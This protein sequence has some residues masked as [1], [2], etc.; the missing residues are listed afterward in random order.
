MM[1][2]YEFFALLSTIDP[3]LAP[4]PLPNVHIAVSYPSWK[5]ICDAV[6]H[7]YQYDITLVF[8]K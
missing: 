1:N 7:L 5:E 8:N 6:D 3:M 2:E 4:I